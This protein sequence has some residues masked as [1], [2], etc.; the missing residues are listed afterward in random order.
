MTSSCDA[1]KVN[2]PC[3]RLL[4]KQQPITLKMVSSH[5]WTDRRVACVMHKK[6]P[7]LLSKVE[8]S[9][10]RKVPAHTNVYS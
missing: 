9:N 8:V 2:R 10:S 6:Q 4:S 7:I 3:K 1:E 5:S